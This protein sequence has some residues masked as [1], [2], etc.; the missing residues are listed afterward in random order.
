MRSFFKKGVVEQGQDLAAYVRLTKVVTAFML[1]FNYDIKKS[2][3]IAYPAGKI[4]KKQ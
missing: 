2:L 1:S 4:K 3:F